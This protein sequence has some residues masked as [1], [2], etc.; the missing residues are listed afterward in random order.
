MEGTKPP[1]PSTALSHS[2]P[3]PSLSSIGK[4]GMSPFR[5]ASTSYVVHKIILTALQASGQH[6]LHLGGSPVPDP[7]QPCQVG[8]QGSTDSPVKPQQQPE[9]CC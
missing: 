9:H 7:V 5:C 2:S 3:S 6:L 8:A 4:Q 1:Q